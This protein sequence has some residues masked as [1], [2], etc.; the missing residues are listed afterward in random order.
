MKLG[1]FVMRRAAKAIGKPTKKACARTPFSKS[2]N[3]KGDFTTAV[4]GSTAK[5]CVAKTQGR[6]WAFGSPE[7]RP[8]F[9]AAIPNR[10]PT[11][12]TCATGSSFATHL[13]LPFRIM[14]TASIP[15]NVRQALRNEP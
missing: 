9:Q 14:L 2:G 11:N 13:T 10:L 3:D 7:D 4:Y 15:C 8:I 6:R 5:G 1:W 12:R